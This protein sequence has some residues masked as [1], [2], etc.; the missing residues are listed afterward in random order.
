MKDFR[1]LLKNRDMKDGMRLLER[2]KLGDYELSIQASEHHYS[3]PKE[4]LNNL[5]DYEDMEV[6][7]FKNNE[8]VNIEEDS[9]FNGWKDR[10]EFLKSYDGMV[11]AY[12]PIKIIQSLY[13]YLEKSISR[14]SIIN[15]LTI[16]QL[17]TFKGYTRFIKCHALQLTVINES[18]SAI[19]NYFLSKATNL[20]NEFNEIDLLTCD[21]KYL[22]DLCKESSVLYFSFKYYKNSKNCN[23]E[24][25]QKYLIKLKDLLSEED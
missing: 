9:F 18:E 3:Y 12:T 4:T 15:K 2:I 25:M 20:N 17:K 6:A 13:D 21:K 1:E 23:L 19:K 14:K 5:F 11:G 24:E 22:L 7:I 16:E 10:E 8:F